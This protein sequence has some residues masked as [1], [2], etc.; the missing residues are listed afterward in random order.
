MCSEDAFAWSNAT[1]PGHLEQM[2]PFQ[3]DAGAEVAD[4]R[5]PAPA[6]RTLYTSAAG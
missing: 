5:A 6:R 1:V 2:H 3:L 4:L